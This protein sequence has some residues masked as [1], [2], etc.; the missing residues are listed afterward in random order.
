MS[1]SLRSIIW[2]SE[3]D[4][5]IFPQISF[6]FL[7]FPC[8]FVSTIFEKVAHLWK[9]GHFPQNFTKNP[10]SKS[11]FLS[12]PLR[13]LRQFLPLR[14]LLFCK[15]NQRHEE[16]CVNT[17]G[18]IRCFRVFFFLSEEADKQRL[19]RFSF[20]FRVWFWL[21]LVLISWPKFKTLFSKLGSFY[22]FL[23]ISHVGFLD[24]C[25]LCHKNLVWRKPFCIFF[26]R[27]IDVQWGPERIVLI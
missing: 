10:G 22:H 11:S 14:V 27:V 4:K 26:C 3:C 6:F 13:N 12:Y 23:V 25:C 18:Q 7:L 24:R 16:L 5:S 1:S 19:F 20:F 15:K 21:G 8:F 17:E 9:G 2:A